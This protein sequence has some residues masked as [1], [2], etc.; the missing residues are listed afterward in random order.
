MNETLTDNVPNKAVVPARWR[1]D[2]CGHSTGPDYVL[3]S[4]LDAAPAA[5]I[6]RMT[7]GGFAVDQP[8][9]RKDDYNIT[10]G[11]SQISG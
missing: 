3:E 7:Q 4:T 9:I 11:Y 8:H 6:G 10:S 5:S 2:S 1:R